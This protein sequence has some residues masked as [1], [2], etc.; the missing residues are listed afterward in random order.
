MRRL[1]NGFNREELLGIWKDFVEV[2]MRYVIL[3]GRYKRFHT[4]LFP[5]LNHFCNDIKVNFPYWII[6]FLEDSVQKIMVGDKVLPL[7]Q[8]LIY[9]LYNFQLVLTPTLAFNT[10]IYNPQLVENIHDISP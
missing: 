4:Y 1:Q 3:D 9:A 7:H 10:R 2:L 5:L 6:T 8:S